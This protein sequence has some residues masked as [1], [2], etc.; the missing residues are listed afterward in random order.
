MITTKNNFLLPAGYLPS[1]APYSIFQ[2][3]EELRDGKYSDTPPIAAG[4]E[5]NYMVSQDPLAVNRSPIGGKIIG[6]HG[7]WTQMSRSPKLEWRLLSKL[8][9]QPEVDSNLLTSATKTIDFAQ[10]VGGQYVIFHTVDLDPQYPQGFLKKVIRYAASRKIKIFPECDLKTS[11]APDWIYNHLALYRKFRLP[12]VFD[13][14]TVE[15]NGESLLAEWDKLVSESHGKI[16]KVV[17]H[18]HLNEFQP[19]L[20]MDQGI[21]RSARYKEL[22]KRIKS[23]GYSGYFTFEI[24]PV[25]NQ[26]DKL[27]AGGYTLVG[28]SGLNKI[29][30]VVSALYAR[31]AQAYLYQS[32]VFA[33]KYL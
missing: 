1:V 3:Y 11:R 15:V 30:P 19:Q 27:I 9:F 8:V 22:L 13:S 32:V 18:I 2:Y 23:S 17:G 28:L 26:F 6:V 24:G 25:Q 5:Y 12:I 14:A 20:F 33:G 21:M 4:F 7:P 10:A 31:K 16:E 29:F